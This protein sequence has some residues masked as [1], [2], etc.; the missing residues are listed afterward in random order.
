[1]LSDTQDLFSQYVGAV[2]L[3]STSRH[4]FGLVGPEIHFR[5]RRSTMPARLR[6]LIRTGFMVVIF[7]AART[8]LFS[9]QMTTGTIAGV[10]TDQSGGVIAGATVTVRHLETNAIR[11]SVTVSDGRFNFPGLPVGPYDLAVEMS[12][13]AK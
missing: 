12:G 5:R 11:T 8:P 4:I 3:G 7:A 9:A 10:V 13:F 2:T 6:I 1:M